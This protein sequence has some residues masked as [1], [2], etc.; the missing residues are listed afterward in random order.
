MVHPIVEKI[1]FAGALVVLCLH[2][3]LWTLVDRREAPASQ[4]A[5]LYDND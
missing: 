3:A 1:L 2:F 4:S 5:S